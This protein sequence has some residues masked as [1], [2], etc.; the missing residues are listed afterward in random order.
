MLFAST[1]FLV[2]F[3]PT[4]LLLIYFIR[5]AFG[6]RCAIALLTL[7]SLVSYAWYFPPFLLLLVASV[8]AN[9]W[10]GN[11]V[12]LTGSRLLTSLGI[13]LNLGL[14]GW[15]KYAGLIG[16]LVESV[17]GQSLGVPE[18]LLPLGISFFTF[19]QIA[20]LVD[21]YQ[22][23]TKPSDVLEYLFFVSF[24]PQLIAGPIVHH[25]EL[26]PQLKNTRFAEFNSED[27][28]AGLVL[29]SIGLAKKVLIADRLAPGADTLFEAQAL[30]I[31]LSAAEAWFGMLCYTFQ[32]YFDFSGYADIALGLARMFGLRLPVNFASPYKSTDIIEFWRRWHI[33]LST[34]LRDYLYHPL[35]GNRHGPVRRYANLWIVMLIGGLWHGAGLQFV[36]WGG[37]HGVYLTIAHFWRR[38][39][40]RRLHPAL[41]FALT[42]IG[43][44]IA[45]VY[46][47]A[48]NILQANEI[49]WVMCGGGVDL[50]STDIYANQALPSVVLTFAILIAFFAPNSL[51]IEERVLNQSLGTKS[52]AWFAFSGSFAALALSQI[53]SSGGHAFIYFQF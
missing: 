51:E 5:H 37:L 43:V 23:K 7:S 47:R 50:F 2:G 32:I 33:S 52:V 31:Q 41:A 25:K 15:Y 11:L 14:L 53:Y 21:I 38:S 8:V 39:T 40:D 36:V 42:F 34:F 27:I 35:G 29:L 49:I 19:Q 12:Y 48:D 13:I 9:Y 30:G 22:Q 10:L 1:T 17:S 44:V 4:V 28:A 16:D 45:W 20:Y 3:L 18:I 26:M 24:F 6:A 46:F